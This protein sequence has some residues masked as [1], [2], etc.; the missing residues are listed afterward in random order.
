[1]TLSDATRFTKLS[2][3]LSAD[4]LSTRCCIARQVINSY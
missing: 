4:Q 3:R 1:M 2:C